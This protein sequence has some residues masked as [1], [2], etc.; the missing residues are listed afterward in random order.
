MGI[1]AL[2][3]TRRGELDVYLV[4]A[5][6]MVEGAQVY[7]RGGDPV[8]RT[9]A[10]TYPPFFAL[11]FVP[12]LGFSEPVGAALWALASWVALVAIAWMI[13]RTV[14]SFVTD[15]QARDRRLTAVFWIALVALIG[16]HLLSILEALSHDV[17]T[18][19]L[20]TA[21]VYGLSL[22]RQR[23]AGVCAGIAAACKA[24]PL[25]FAPVFMWQRRWSATACVVLA[26][27]LCTWLPDL[28]HPNKAQIPWALDWY[29]TFLSNVR[30]GA[31]VEAPGGWQAWS[32]AN[33]SLSGS[34]YR[35]LNP[36][37]TRPDEAERDISVW[38]PGPHGTKAVTLA[39]QVGVLVLMLWAA[40][41]R[42]A[43]EREG[44]QDWPL[45][46]FGQ[47]AIVATAMPLLSPMSSKSHFGILILPVAYCLT[48]YLYRR[49]DRAVLVLLASTFVIGTLTMKSLVGHSWGRYL[50]GCGTVTWCALASLI[51]A[52]RTLQLQ[53]RELRSAG[54]IQTT[55][56]SAAGVIGSA[57]H[58]AGPRAPHAIGKPAT[59][60]S[61]ARGRNRD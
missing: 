19:L 41:P 25:L 32:E 22:G 7:V 20:V 56:R 10:F 47:G 40:W 4:G 44:R 21:C 13:D 54:D 33:Q 6:R 3:Q 11:V 27:A 31:T 18:L 39:A 14:A 30:P 53:L 23:A 48:Y 45:V 51:A 24:T 15:E 26:A 9:N 16:R 43:P 42:R 12:L 50:L 37:T 1:E 52:A 8:Y 36:P 59:T 61:A 49:R 55:L 60:S 58:S 35:L 2:Y 46:E 57:A 34:L 29:Q 17:L 38:N 28:T 5:E